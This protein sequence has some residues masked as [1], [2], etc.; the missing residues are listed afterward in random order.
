MPSPNRGG[1]DVLPARGPDALP[2]VHGHGH[3]HHH[4]HHDHHHRNGNA[5]QGEALRTLLG[6][7]L[8][9]K[10]PSPSRSS[11][12][13]GTASPLPTLSFPHSQSYASTNAT[14]SPQPP[15]TPHHHHHTHHPFSYPYPHIQPYPH[16]HPHSHSH[17]H[18]SSHSPMHPKLGV[19]HHEPA[20]PS[21]LSNSNTPLP[22]TDSSQLFG[23]RPGRMSRSSSL[24][25]SNFLH[26][27]SAVTKTRSDPPTSRQ[28]P[29]SPDVLPDV[30]V[31]VENG[32]GTR[33][34]TVPANVAAMDTASRNK[35]LKTLEGKTTAWDA[36][37]HGSFS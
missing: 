33:T 18:P 28:A 22:I 29:A 9:P 20:S 26:T 36:L 15:G 17:S 25:N 35:F 32:N 23:P 4:H 10:R 31:T 24:S 16:A 3:E 19:D 14:P 2:S 21:P 11:S 7:I 37:I 34:V 12:S 30:V 13:S 6:S 1:S 27:H 8:A 5:Q